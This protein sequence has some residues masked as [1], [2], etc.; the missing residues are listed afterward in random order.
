M[1]LLIKYFK[2]LRF[3]KKLF[4]SYTVV[5][6]IPIM[7]LGLYS[8][9]R[10]ITFLQEQ[11]KTNLYESIKQTADN[12]NYKLKKYNN[13]LDFIAYNTRIQQMFSN[14]YTNYLVL[15]TD[16]K[17]YF[18]PFF[19]NIMYLNNDINQVTI[20]T[21]NNIP[22]YG[23]YIKNR[24]S[25]GNLSWYGAAGEKTSWYN[26]NGKFFGV[27]KLTDLY[28]NQKLG[29]VYISPIYDRLFE[30]AVFSKM[31]GYGIIVA[32]KKNN[33]IFTKDTFNEKNIN[34]V[35]ALVLNVGE[36]SIKVKGD[37]YLVLKS[38]IY[39]AEWMLYYYMPSDRITIN[40]K[41]IIVATV[42]IIGVCILVLLLLIWLFSNT[43]VKR[44]HW[45]NRKMNLV[46]EGDLQI[47]V[48]SQSKDEIGELINDFGD[49]LGKINTLINEVYQSKIT[50]KEAELKA[51][52]A[53]INPHFLY[54]TLSLINWKAIQI[55]AMDISQLANTISKF[56]RTTL[57]N[58]K[59]I[60]SVRDEMDN[61]K[62][63]LD[64]QLIMHNFNFDVV[65]TIDEEIYKYN[66]IKLMLQPI[67]ENAIVH[68]IEKK[69][70]ERGRLEISGSI[71][72]ENIII[73]VRD[74]GGGISENTIEQI[75]IAKSKGYGLNNVQ[76]R[77]KLFFGEKFG[78][79]IES[80]ISRGTYIK[81]VLPKYTGEC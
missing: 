5:V 43:F 61:I 38:D 54:N 31:N 41:S 58:G 10:S 48:H 62:A 14:N 32:D 37:N 6:I 45:L 76:E 26:L 23:K 7:V 35:R 69:R 39:E 8:Y 15:S 68:A 40:A 57:N 64:I 80:E 47:E 16:I 1:E 55:G 30:D 3:K 36:G 49:M 18:E 65:Y 71:K 46:K 42:I 9:N 17:D 22:E 19:N 44:I 11:A 29:V 77:I 81:V 2:N 73:V 28:S 51:L 72:D 13:V 50:Q 52:Q 78:I 75:F 59:N 67:V 79:H 12:I 4:L 25:A 74:N 27:R 20:Y 53:Q 66:T 33:I 56:Y 70:G 34:E 60:I 21:E 63:Y 24:D